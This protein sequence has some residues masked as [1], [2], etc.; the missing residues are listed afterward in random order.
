VIQ[1][2]TYGYRL[3]CDTEATAS[4]EQRRGL[5]INKL[6]LRLIAGRRLPDAHGYDLLRLAESEADESQL[7]LQIYT[8]D[9]FLAELERIVD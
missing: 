5:K 2:K 7:Q 3:D 4:I 6:K 9:G 8:W 1:L